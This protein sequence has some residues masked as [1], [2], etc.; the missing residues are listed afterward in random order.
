MH[1]Q[2]PVELLRLVVDHFTLPPFTSSFRTEALEQES[3]SSLYSLCLTSR[4]FHEIARPLLYSFVRIPTCKSIETLSLLVEDYKKDDRR[5]SVETVVFSHDNEEMYDSGNSETLKRLSGEVPAALVAVKHFISY[6]EFWSLE[7]IHSSNLSR[8]F[9]NRIDVDTT[10]ISRLIFP[11]LEVLGLYTV[12]LHP[13]ALPVASFPSLRHLSLDNGDGNLS[14][15]EENTLASLLPQLDSVILLSDITLLAMRTI[16][17]LPL[18]SILVNLPVHWLDLQK[19]ESCVVN[20]RLVVN[21][22]VED[23]ADKAC[24]SSIDAFA[25]RLKDPSQFPRLQSVY[26]PPLS[27]LSE[28]FRTDE[29][30]AAIGNV[31]L[32]AKDRDIL[33]ITEEQ[34]NQLKGECQISEDFMKRMTQKRIARDVAEGE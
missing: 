30:I 10:M 4:V 8:V 11:C 19:I 18:A 13:N 20:L 33:V 7:K 9:L 27:S 17:S 24:A 34:S 14:L 25:S 6:S 21:N 15:S 1:R 28:D 26:L 32:T 22:I 29:F 12:D 16:P 2:L 5:S 23:V 3:R 31:E